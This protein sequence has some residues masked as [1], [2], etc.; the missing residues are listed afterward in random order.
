MDLENLRY[1]YFLTEIFVLGQKAAGV[2]GFNNIQDY[3]T[4]QRQCLESGKLFEDPEFPP[5]GNWLRPHEICKNQGFGS[6]KFFIDSVSRFDIKQ[7]RLGDCWFLAAMAAV[8]ASRAKFNRI[9]CKDNSFDENYAGIFHF[10]FWLYGKWVEV[11]VD[12][13]LP[14]NI[15][16]QLDC[17]RSN[18]PNEFW[19][20]LLEKAYAKV[21]G[22]YKALEAGVSCDAFED[23][24]GGVSEIFNLS[25]PPKNMFAIMQKAI[26]RRSLMACSLKPDPKQ[27]EAIG[28]NG[29]IQGHAYTVTDAKTI[30][31]HISGEV[32][33]VD[34]VRLRN[35]WGTKEWNGS[36]SDGKVEWQ[37]LTSDQRKE[38]EIKNEEDGEF[39]MSY[40][41][42]ISYFERLDLCNTTAQSLDEERREDYTWHTKSY[43]GAWIKGKTAGGCKNNRE[44]FQ[45]NPQYIVTLT[46]DDV[47]YNQGR[48]NLMISLMQKYGRSTTSRPN[49]FNIGFAVFRLDESYLKNIS[50]RNT[51]IT[52]T[53]PAER[54]TFINSRGV[55]ARYK[56]EPGHY[57]I[58]P[59]TFHKDQEN[60]FLLRVSYEKKI[61]KNKLK[62]V[63][64]KE[65][66]E[67][68]EDTG[69]FITGDNF[70]P[71][72][73]DDFKSCNMT[74]GEPPSNKSQS[75]E[76]QKIEKL[77]SDAAGSNEEIGWL[78]LK[79]ILDSSIPE[80]S[81][82]KGFYSDYKNDG[83]SRDICRSIIAMMDTDNSRKLSMGE[84]KKFYATF[85]KWKVRTCNSYYYKR[86]TT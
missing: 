30:D 52:Y 12:D 6:P 14:V 59:S 37:L 38:L 76:T 16:G 21:F 8:T 20:A 15:F 42:F 43:D 36:W 19:S 83:F 27:T 60:E 85:T 54:T 22:G 51:F 72:K 39:W 25:N 24:S 74:P 82:T 55:T 17:L 75:S 70:T 9:V 78:E 2:R 61:D 3:Y 40:D 79:T 10:R 80:E 49:Y 53:N 26:K 62:V 48:C 44:T 28:S 84:F 73:A 32:I 58:V 46:T 31:I 69:N 66:N 23:F 11:V 57:L 47:T 65:L 4:I 41:D 64:F 13:R 81:R 77:F 35:P 67:H 68:L 1:K 50:L 45:N 5:T 56:L 7:G 86:K 63:T 33:N 34:L 29:L 71:C 18:E